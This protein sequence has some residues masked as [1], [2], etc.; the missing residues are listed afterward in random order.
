MISCNIWLDE[1]LELTK[2]RGGENSFNNYFYSKI[3][4]PKKWRINFEY[5][6]V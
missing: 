3:R 5:T 4:T 6:K 1:F 2:Q